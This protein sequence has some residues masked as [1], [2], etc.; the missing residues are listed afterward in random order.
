MKIEKLFGVNKSNLREKWSNLSALSKEVNDKKTV[1]I[2]KIERMQKK[3]FGNKP[4]L[5]ATCWFVIEV[6]FLPNNYVGVRMED[7][8][9][10]NYAI[11]KHDIESDKLTVVIESE[12]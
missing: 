12:L 7:G 10:E 2:Q 4:V 1:L 5:G 9:I 3:L 8:H 6:S 11:L